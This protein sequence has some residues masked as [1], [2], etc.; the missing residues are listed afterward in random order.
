MA[1]LFVFCKSNRITSKQTMSSPQHLNCNF[2]HIKKI[3]LWIAI[4]CCSLIW[5]LWRCWA[6][7][8]TSTLI[9]TTTIKGELSIKRTLQLTTTTTSSST[10]SMHHV[11]SGG[12]IPNVRGAFQKK[13][14]IQLYQ[15]LSNSYNTMVFAHSSNPRRQNL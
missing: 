13:P 9:Q 12:A 5:F 8:S 15:T 7:D 6:Y 11:R 3:V 4:N 14:S 1:S 10:S 2:I